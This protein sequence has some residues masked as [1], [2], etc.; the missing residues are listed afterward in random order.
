MAET[1]VPTYSAILM[2]YIGVKSHR[3]TK[4]KINDVE[5]K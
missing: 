1:F 2:R 4:T 5:Q 3:R